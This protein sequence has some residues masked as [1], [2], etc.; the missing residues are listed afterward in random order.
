MDN[1]TLGYFSDEEISIII[2]TLN[3]SRSNSTVILSLRERF[4]AEQEIRKRITTEI[5]QTDVDREHALPSD[6]YY[7][8]TNPL[9]TIFPN[10]PVHDKTFE[11]VFVPK[12]YWIK[13]KRTLLDPI[14]IGNYFYR[15]YDICPTDFY[16][17]GIDSDIGQ[18]YICN[19]SPEEARNILDK[20]GFVENPSLIFSWQDSWR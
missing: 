14:S 17:A 2:D 15:F 3:S 8:I 5:D 4:L 11:I 6:F 18:L 16:H 13:E 19:F 12:Y 10:G 20:I 9:K 7:F 1:T